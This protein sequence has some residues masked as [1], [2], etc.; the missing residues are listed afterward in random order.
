VTAR[1][2]LRTNEDDRYFN[3]KIQQMP[4][5]GYTKIFERMH[6]HP[7]IEVRTST[8]FKD[9]KD[10][11]EFGH[12]VW[13]GPVDEFFDHRFGKLPYRSLEFVTKSEPTPD[14]RKK[15]PAATVNYP[16]IEV[17]WTRI[18]EYRHM[19]ARTSTTGRRCTS[20]TR[21]RRATPTT[22]SRTTSRA[23][24]TS[25]TSTRRADPGWVTFVGRLARYQYL[26]MDQVVGQALS[27]FDK[28]VESG[29]VKVADAAGA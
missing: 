16:T 24:C 4:A 9:V 25:S 22:P 20:S 3:D 15:L 5:E 19:T 2:P 18:T 23:R 29:Q 11:I 21:A 14:G 26:N 6:D 1:I 13:T 17:E 28:L 8:H 27:T 12:L 7:N 10:E